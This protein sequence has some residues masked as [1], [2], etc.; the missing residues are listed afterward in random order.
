MLVSI[1][2]IFKIGIGPSS[3]HTIGPMVAGNLFLG[4]IYKR[5]LMP[6]IERV[7]VNLYGSMALTGVGHGSLSAVVIG[8]MGK[9]ADEINPDI[10]P[11]L[12]DDV[13][14]EQKLALDEKHIVPF[15]YDNDIVL[16]K[17]EFLPYHSNG[18]KFIAYDADGN[19]LL[20]KH[21]YSIG[22]GFVMSQKG[23]NKGKEITPKT[24][25]PYS[26]YSAKELL[27]KC[28]K[29]K[30]SIAEMMMANEAYNSSKEEVFN[31]IMNIRN[32]MSDA[33]ERGCTKD[34]I[35]GGGIG[36][37]RRAKHFYEKLKARFEENRYDP[38][39]IIDW[40]NLWA[41]A[42]SEENA[43]GG[44]VVTAPTNGAAGVLPAV[45]RYYERYCPTASQQGVVDF[46]L[47]AGAI[48]NLYKNNASISGA[49][50]GC[51]GEIGVACSM[52]A[53]GLAAALGGT[54]EQIENAA[55]IGME[56]NLGL[57][58]DPVAGLVQI[59]CIERN[60]MGAIKAINAARLALRGDGKHFISLDSVIETMRQTGLDMQAK[61]KETSTGGLAVNFVE[62]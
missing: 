54:A 28:R 37:R 35:L 42:A 51:Q 15:S 47:T 45:L 43:G 58:C 59:P 24:E 55:E 10:I 39:D 3:S 33:I 41:F 52:A 23:L 19:E 32:V 27:D 2:D 30:L 12:I 21:Y 11:L 7:Q 38:L 61:Y 34:G 6:Q 49:E 40:I 60:A 1:F 8:L 29:S 22:G 53:A 56:H 20:A 14:K 57:T 4:S 48:A 26:F 50:V 62:C 25:V 9:K 16:Y 46:I 13:K 36:V 5:N 31:K 18:M 44:R 17:E